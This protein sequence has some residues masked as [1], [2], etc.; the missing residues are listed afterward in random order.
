MGWISKRSMT[1]KKLGINCLAAENAPNASEGE[2]NS[3][4][5]S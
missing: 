5:H 3:D 4:I 2:L 1:A